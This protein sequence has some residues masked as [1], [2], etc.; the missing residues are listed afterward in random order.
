MAKFLALYSGSPS[1]VSEIMANMTP[2][3]M[4]KGMEPWIEWM[5]R[6]GDSIV[7]AGAPLMGGQLISPAGVSPSNADISGYSILEADDMKAALALMDG[8]PHLSWLEGATIQVFECV[9]LGMP[10]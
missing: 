9:S 5:T 1:E 7:D 2:E 10:E 8:H 3:E 6:C 4:Q